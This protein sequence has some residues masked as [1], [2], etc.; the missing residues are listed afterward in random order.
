MNLGLQNEKN[1]YIINISADAEFFNAIF[2]NLF[3]LMISTVTSYCTQSLEEDMDIV[4]PRKLLFFFWC[5]FFSRHLYIMNYLRSLDKVTPGIF[6]SVYKI[7]IGCVK[8]LLYLKS[9]LHMTEST[10]CYLRD[11]LQVLQFTVVTD[12]KWL[13]K[14]S[15]SLWHLVIYVYVYILFKLIL[16]F[17]KHVIHK[18]CIW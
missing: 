9:I 7:K 15:N 13:K 18:I 17:W 8:I 5:G 16:G 2:L 14:F 12:R 6:Y 3:I 1:I 4:Q 10:V 11:K